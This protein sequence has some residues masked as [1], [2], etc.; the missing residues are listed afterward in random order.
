MVKKQK[1]HTIQKRRR[2]EE[3]EEK[4]HSFTAFT[5]THRTAIYVC[6]HY[7]YYYYYVVAV[8]CVFYAY[9]VHTQS[10]GLQAINSLYSWREQLLRRVSGCV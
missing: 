3:G 4:N 1:R 7:Y 5:F 8:V 2:V 9:S 6:E 10:K